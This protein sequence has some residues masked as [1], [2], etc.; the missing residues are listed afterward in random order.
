MHPRI[1]NLM[2][3]AG[4]L[5][6]FPVAGQTLG[7]GQTPAI[8]LQ[9]PGQAVAGGTAQDGGQ[10]AE[11]ILQAL[12]DHEA[13]K[14]QNTRA[15]AQ[16]VEALAV[17]NAQNSFYITKRVKLIGDLWRAAPDHPQLASLM[18]YRWQN[19]NKIY[20][21]DITSEVEEFAKVHPEA[22]E[23]ILNGRYQV[24]FNDI[25]LNSRNAPERALE[26][27]DSFVAAY[28]DSPR[29]ATLLAS[30]A[31]ALRSNQKIVAKI[32]QRLIENYPGTREAKSALAKMRQ[33]KGVGQP[34]ELAFTDHLTG[35]PI[36]MNELEG[37]V[38]VIDFWATWCG[39]C[40]AE[41]PHMKEL[42]KEYKD[43]GVEFIGVSLDQAPEKGGDTAL[44]NYCEK[45]GVTWP[46]YYQGNY[47]QSEFSTSWGIRGIPALF[48]IDKKGIL[49]STKAR[50]KLDEL[51]PLLLAK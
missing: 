30:A 34:F 11:D 38:V 7:Q 31:G 28:P 1:R 19:A 40:I 16:D 51:I 29:G 37:K 32:N 39:P 5:I 3:A 18:M 27:A 24:A 25:R 36:S 46:Q 8:P 4:A 41:I 26:A 12:R 23:A 9:Q 20:R 10:S 50:G 21:L 44:T 35:R 6:A 45:N 43:Q 14:P 13:L 42:Y 33:A 48:I 2:V 15:I 47:W 22:D 17:Y 49:H